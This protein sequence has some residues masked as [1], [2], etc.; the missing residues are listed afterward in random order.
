MIAARTDDLIATALQPAWN[1]IL[2]MVRQLAAQ[3]DGVEPDERAI[4]YAG[5]NARQAFVEIERLAARANTIRS[6][7]SYLRRGNVGED[8]HGAFSEFR[9]PEAWD[10][11]AQFANAAARLIAVATSEAGSWVPTLAEQDRRIGEWRAENDPQIRREQQ[12]L[13]S[14]RGQVTLT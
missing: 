4:L 2:E 7:W 3:L 13:K 14:A 11:Q 9:N 5:E 1:E 12:L 6:A 8:V 10:F